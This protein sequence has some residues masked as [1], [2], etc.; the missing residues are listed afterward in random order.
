M[1]EQGAPGKTQTEEQS[2]Q[3]VEKKERL[4]GRSVGMFSEYEGMHRGRLRS[5]WN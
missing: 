2:L 3:N 4:L 1:D 5:T